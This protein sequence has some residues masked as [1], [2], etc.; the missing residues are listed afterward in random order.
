MFMRADAFRDL[1][2][3]DHSLGMNGKKLGLAEET[4]WFLRLQ[5][6]GAPIGYV[7]GALVHHWVNPRDITRMGLLRRALQAGI[8]S[9]RVFHVPRPPQGWLGWCRHAVSATVRGRLHMGEQVYL[10]LELGRL[11]ATSRLGRSPA[12][13]P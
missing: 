6:T 4:E 9:V 11:W 12:S 13:R 3:F 7:A 1:G 5:R 2:G 10:M 8:V